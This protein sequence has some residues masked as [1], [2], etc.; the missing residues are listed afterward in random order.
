MK[1]GILP[2]QNR[3]SFLL[4]GSAI[5][6]MILKELMSS[7][8]IIHICSTTDSFRITVSTL[9]A[10][11]K[12]QGS[13]TSCSLYFLIDRSYLVPLSFCHNFSLPGLRKCGT[14]PPLNYMVILTFSCFCL[15]PRLNGF[16]AFWYLLFLRVDREQSLMCE[17]TFYE[18]TGISAE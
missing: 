3:R 17:M 5:G 14:C 6:G 4:L 10:W 9:L 2:E 1:T 12:F 11:G 18:R 16:F 13:S 8:T 7:S 15:L